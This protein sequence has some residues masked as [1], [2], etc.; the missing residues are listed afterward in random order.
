MTIW[1]SF[2][3]ARMTRSNIV[4]HTKRSMATESKSTPSSFKTVLVAGGSYA[5][6]EAVRILSEILPET[7]KIV[8]L[9]RNSH[10]NHVY[11]FPRYS[12]VDG[13]TH[14]AFIPY[15]NV[16]GSP[17]I[18]NRHELIQGT[19]LNIN[20]PSQEAKEGENGIATFVQ[21]S[22]ERSIAFDHLIYALGSYR[23]GSIDL[24]KSMYSGKKVD[25]IENVKEIQKS[26]EAAKKIVIV[27]SG[28]LGIEFA[29]DIA[30]HYTGAQAK[31]VTLLSSSAKLLPK[32]KDE[33][34]ERTYSWLIEHGVDVHLGE[35]LAEQE[36]DIN[37]EIKVKTN[38][39]NTIQADLV[40]DCTGLK[41][42]TAPLKPIL[43]ENWQDQTPAWTNEQ[44]QLLDVSPDRLSTKSHI[45]ENIF[46]AGDAGHGFG[47]HK[48]GANAREQAG[49]ASRNICRQIALAQMSSSWAKRFL[50]NNGEQLEKYEPGPISIKVSLGIKDAISQGEY[51]VAY[52]KG[53]GRPDMNVEKHWK[54]RGLS[55]K[56]MYL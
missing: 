25:G 7:H 50:A 12:V 6:H 51:G 4:N 34:H 27:G 42:N 43:G 31:D 17:L 28:P 22:E 44:L 23:P 36:E 35:R 10:F 26:I 16:F 49:I 14:K 30:D 55:T 5:G 11:V 18:G 1:R 33:I 9:E 8:L 21:N 40:L 29:A 38:R 32:L 39:G 48:N 54:R 37:G 19:L 2:R 41:A 20:P 46:V 13:H 52:R 53:E 15:T 56:D 47:A 45:F 24:W 3:V